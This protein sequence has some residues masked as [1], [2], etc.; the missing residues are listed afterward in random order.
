[1]QKKPF[2]TVD[3]RSVDLYTVSN[4]NGME[5]TVTNY[6]CI[7]TSLKVPD[8]NN[9]HKDVVLGYN[10]VKSYVDN[11]YYF[12]AAIGR[13]GNRIGGAKFTLEGKEYNVT[14]NEGPNSLHG[15]SKGFDKVVWDAEAFKNET[16][17]GLEFSYVSKDGEEGFP[18]TLTLKIT[19]TLTNNNE[20]RIDYFATTDKQTICNL[21]HHSYFNLN[22]EGN[23]DILG[24]KLMINGSR[25]TP[26]DSTLIPTGEL[27]SVEGTPFNFLKSVEIGARIGSDD[28]QL[29]LAEGYD[30]NWVLDRPE[31]SKDLFLAATVIEPE[32]GRCMD[33]LTREPGVQFYS[34]NFLD[35]T[36]IGKSGRVYKHRYGFCLETQA[37]P[38]SPNKPD[39]PTTVLKPGETY[40][41]TT[42]YRFYN[43]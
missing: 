6:G 42:V 10:D 13:C 19:Y 26:V 3:G 27:K 21:T 35:G 30:H 43:R 33:V 40:K 14:K 11:N 17:G 4:I 20:F 37:Y 32:S 9:I 38:D 5:M 15:G 41:T 29:K 24:H 31:G 8:K 34:G 28:K 25:F 36:L 23:G 12:G 18:G 1:M 2:G 7:V 16:G 39:F 22:G